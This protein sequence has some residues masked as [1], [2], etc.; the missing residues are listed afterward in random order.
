MLSR[1]ILAAC[2]LVAVPAVAVS[3]E[4]VWSPVALN[5]AYVLAQG[6]T[7]EVILCGAG[8]VVGDSIRVT[9]LLPV[10]MRTTDPATARGDAC[11]EGTVVTWHNH[12]WTGPQA[13]DGVEKPAE[14]C[15]L[16]R[17]DRT[18][19]V[20]TRTPWIAVSVGRGDP[21]FTWLCWWSQAQ[22]DPRPLTLPAL[23]GQRL[24]YWSE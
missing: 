17:T 9:D 21:K 22:L 14:W 24:K 1:I 7:N 3:Q 8:E 10:Y 19:A 5:R 12:P 13:Q 6:L 23:D 16:S 18:S 4:L 20:R 2:L 15:S 11:P